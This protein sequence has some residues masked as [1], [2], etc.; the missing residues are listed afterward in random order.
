MFLPFSSFFFEEELGW[1]AMTAVPKPAAAVVT[2][3]LWGA[4]RPLPLVRGC[5]GLEDRDSRLSD[6]AV[7]VSVWS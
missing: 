3:T 5:R 7:H 6:S 2:P 1:D 4:G